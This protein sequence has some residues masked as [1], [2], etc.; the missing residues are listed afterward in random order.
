MV[1]CEGAVVMNG[2]I[3]GV[4]RTLVHVCSDHPVKE[5][6]TPKVSSHVRI[7]PARCIE[8]CGVSVKFD[9]G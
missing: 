7:K 3:L 1:K 4:R 9:P 6:F 2:I 5:M 8:E